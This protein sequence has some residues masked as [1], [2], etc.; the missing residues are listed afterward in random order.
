MEADQTARII[1][2]ATEDQ[3]AAI[4]EFAPYAEAA[5][6]RGDLFPSQDPNYLAEQAAKVAEHLGVLFT[7]RSSTEEGK[8]G[9]SI[10]ERL[11]IV[12]AVLS[13]VDGVDT[14]TYGPGSRDLIA[15]V[16]TSGLVTVSSYHEFNTKTDDMAGLDSIVSIALDQQKADYS[17][18]AIM[19]NTPSIARAII[20][21]AN[22]VSRKTIVMGMG[23]HG[24][25]TREAA[26]LGGLP[27]VY[28]SAVLPGDDSAPV[29]AGQ[30]NR[31]EAARLLREYR[32][33]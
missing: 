21:Y 33:G 20:D 15:Q 16:R 26:I 30:L 14:E 5:E 2:I 32:Q 10:D 4:A 9:G 27:A 19:A 29:V 25:E 22:T 23:L 8:W 3:V 6:L 17:K 12:E 11:T 31:L 1:T 28:I 7:L 18:L 24:K 13:V